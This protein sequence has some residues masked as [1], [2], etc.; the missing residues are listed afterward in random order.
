MARTDH[1]KTARAATAIRRSSRL[2]TNSS[3]KSYPGLDQ[4]PFYGAQ[5]NMAEPRR[6]PK[7]KASETVLAL[8]KLP[9]NL[10]EEALS[11]L[12]ARDIEEWEGWVELESEPV[13]H[14]TF[15][16]SAKLV[17][18]MSCQAFFNIILRDLGVQD[19][20]AQELFTVQQESIE[21]LP[22]VTPHLRNG[23]AD[24][25]ENL[26]TASY[27]WSNTHQVTKSH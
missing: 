12:T 10:L 1:L 24:R 22:S 27:S 4:V 14:S 15:L 26:C 17:I 7:R 16:R 19:V 18:L 6:N 20:R 23:L 2:A 21:L 13:S 25:S 8:A 3:H 11:P 5:I 9:D